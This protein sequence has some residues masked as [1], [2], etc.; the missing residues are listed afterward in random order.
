MQKDAH[1][2]NAAKG[3]AVIF[4]AKRKMYCD[5]SIVRLGGPQLMAALKIF[6]CYSHADA[7]WLGRLKIHLRPLV[8]RGEIDY[9]DDT[10]ITG[11]QKWRDEIRMALE[12]AN[13]AILLISSDFY[14]SDFI[15]KEELPPLLEAEKKRGLLIL[16]VQIGA[17]RFSRDEV[18]AEYQT[19]NQPNAPIQSLSK[20]EQEKVFDDLV[21]QIET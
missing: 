15:E 17:S 20:H 9:W 5:T 1:I 14:A 19:V 11:G 13:V 18:L 6:V 2:F 7:E 8:R 12:E 21:R 10:R 16:G 4:L 3:K